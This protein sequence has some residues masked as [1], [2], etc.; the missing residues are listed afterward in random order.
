MAEILDSDFSWSIF[1]TFFEIYCEI[2][3][4]I[5]GFCIVL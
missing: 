3:I 2:V 1:L 4:K 5:I